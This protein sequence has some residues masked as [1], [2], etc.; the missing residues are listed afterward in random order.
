MSDIS[1][2]LCLNFLLNFIGETWL[3]VKPYFLSRDYWS[4]FRQFASGLPCY[5]CKYGTYIL[6]CCLSQVD[7]GY[8]ATLVSICHYSGDSLKCMCVGCVFLVGKNM[9]ANYIVAPPRIMS[10]TLRC[11]GTGLHFR[12]LGYIR[13]CW[14]M[15]RGRCI[16]VDTRPSRPIS[17]SR[18]CPG[19]AL[20]ISV[21][22]LGTEGLPAWGIWRQC[23]SSRPMVTSWMLPWAPLWPK[24]C[25]G[26]CA[27][28]MPAP[29][30]TGCWS[31]RRLWNG[32][33]TSGH[34]G[35]WFTVVLDRPC[36]LPYAWLRLAHGM[37]H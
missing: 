37:C 30:T 36:G 28:S 26:G 29:T 18:R 24:R 32:S 7:H 31:F 6:Q 15:P 27:I 1:W 5:S 10:R 9:A 23:I 20:I 2:E 4:N 35:A 16:I 3:Q 12:A 19:S 11:Q 13:H 34:C 22:H 33:R 17:E 14:G 25:L 21:F 8:Y